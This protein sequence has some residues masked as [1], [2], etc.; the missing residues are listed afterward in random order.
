MVIFAGLMF[1]TA[2]A[3]L[4]RNILALLEPDDEIPSHYS[5]EKYATTDMGVAAAAR[6][7]CRQSLSLGRPVKRPV[8]QPKSAPEIVEDSPGH[9]V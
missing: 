3:F 5:F 8:A 4:L 2:I 1:I 9:G 7:A 6:D